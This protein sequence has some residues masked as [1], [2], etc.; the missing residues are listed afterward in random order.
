VKAC[1]MCGGAGTRLRPLTFERPKPLVPLLNRPS[2][3]HLVDMLTDNGFDDIVVTLGSRTGSI[4]SVL[5]DGSAWGARIRYSYEKNKLGTAG[6]VKNAEKMLDPGNQPLLVVG[7]DHVLDFSLREFYQY[8]RGHGGPATIAVLGV[9]DPSEYGIM[10]IGSDFKIRRFLEKPGPGQVFSNVASTGIY[11]IEPEVLKKI[12]L[13]FFDFARD[14]FP[15][16]LNDG[17]DIHGYFVQGRWSD[18]GS[19]REY[20]EAMRWML[21]TRE[22]SYLKGTVR[23]EDSKLVGRIYLGN[24]A[25]IGRKCS[26]V[27]P[28][29][30]GR[31]LVL[32]EMV[33]V[34][35]YTSIGENCQVDDGS[36]ILSSILLDDVQ[37]S[38]RCSVSGAILDSN[39]Q[40]GEDTVIENDVVIGPRVKIGH[41]VTVESGVR[42]WPDLEIEDGTVVTDD[43]LNPSYETDVAGS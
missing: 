32:G 29:F 11:V 3:V 25:T 39:V 24:N 28:I 27:G 7:G 30:C 43:M 2:V 36:H 22:R 4:E 37:V 23:I 9:D 10:D 15:K 5:G 41:G 6:S 33:L 8:H 38:R 26:M 18:M 20:R 12:P 17:D 21:D 35:P 31:D 34:G 19:P 1:I 40:V 13:K 16:M 14:L 42:V